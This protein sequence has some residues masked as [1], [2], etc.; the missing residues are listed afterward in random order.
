VVTLPQRAA[1][2]A[3][4]ALDDLTGIYDLRRIIEAHVARRA[5]EQMTDAQVELVERALAELEEAA[6]RPDSPLFWEKHRDFHWAVREAGGARRAA[7]AG[8]VRRQG[9][10]RAAGGRA[11][12]GRSGGWR[13]DVPGRQPARALRARR[14]GRRGGARVAAAAGGHA[15]LR[16]GGR[17]RCCGR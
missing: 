6:Q 9:A 14:G 11:Q 12:P 4:V 15:R 3:G 1:V 5:V 8:V 13:G 2:A 17:T 7:A 10:R 16:S